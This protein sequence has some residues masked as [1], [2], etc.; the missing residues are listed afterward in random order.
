MNFLNIINLWL[1]IICQVTT[2]YATVPKSTTFHQLNRAYLI[3]HS[4]Y[5]RPSLSFPTFSFVWNAVTKFP[6][7]TTKFPGRRDREMRSDER[8]WYLGWI[9]TPWGWKCS[10]VPIRPE[11]AFVW[12][13]VIR[14]AVWSPESQEASKSRAEYIS[15][16]GLLLTVKIGTNRSDRAVWP[17]EA[18]WPVRQGPT[19]LTGSSDRSDRSR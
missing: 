4:I 15:W 18:L 17:V 5:W 11:T 16:E 12:S 7:R 10:C 1:D 3:C 8:E 13:R 2:K 19:G 9:C 14:W 6:G